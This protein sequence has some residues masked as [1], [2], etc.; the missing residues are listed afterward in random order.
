M[1]FDTV[2][3]VNDDPFMITWD[4]G[5]R[6]NYDCTY[7]APIHHDNFSPHASLDELINSAKFIFDYIKVVAKYRKD[8]N[9]HISLTGGEPTNNPNF[10]KL[11]NYLKQQSDQLKDVLILRFDLTTN[12]T[13]GPKIIDAVASTFNS[14]TI[15]YHTEADP[16]LKKGVLDCIEKLRHKI[17]VKVNVMF[18]AEHFDECVDLCTKFKQNGTNFIPRLIGE[19]PGGE[20]TYGHRYTSEQLTW[21]NNFWGVKEEPVSNVEKFL[22]KIIPINTFGAGVGRPCCGGRTMCISNETEKEEVKFLTYRKF[23]NWH[24]SVNWYFLHIEQQTDS[25]YHHQTC[26]AKFDKTTG[27]IGKISQGEIIV[28][29]LVN[30]LSNKNMPVIVCPNTFCSCG[31]CTPKSTNKEKLLTNLSRVVDTSVF[32]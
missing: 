12:G 28:T 3:S 2:A 22:K 7:C 8:K 31:M 18:H 27:P 26:Q 10:I 17:Y 21:I 20:K 13:L 24:C 9:F 19:I 11:S 25:V 23:K 32:G 6:C 4:L 5:R 15:S 29:E 16:I 1:K 14:A 30:N